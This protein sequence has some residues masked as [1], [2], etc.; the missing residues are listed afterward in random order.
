MLLGVEGAFGALPG[1]THTTVGYTGGDV[2]HPTY[3]R[4][5]RGRPGHADAVEVEYVPSVISYDDLFATFW[6]THNPTT[7]SRQG[8][9]IGSR[10]RSAVFFDDNDQRATALASRDDHQSVLKREIVA[11]IVPGRSLLARRGLPPAILAAHHGDGI[12]RLLRGDRRVRLAYRPSSSLAKK[13][14]L[15]W[16]AG[17]RSGGLRSSCDSDRSAHQ[18]NPLSRARA[19]ASALWPFLRSAVRCTKADRTLGA[20]KRPRLAARSLRTACS[21]LVAAGDTAALL[22]RTVL[23][24]Q[25]LIHVV[26]LRS[27]THTACPARGR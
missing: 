4:V 8:W 17:A 9:D 15:G 11:Q 19:L 1:V 2:E 16:A 24:R 27:P 23:P 13:T 14:D 10:Y 21:T 22:P 6:S 5:C 26:F 12:V 3:K 7:R 20:T 18:V 25:V